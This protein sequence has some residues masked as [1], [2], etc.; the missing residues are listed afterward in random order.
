MVTG[1]VK[2]TTDFEKGMPNVFA[3]R[4]G[5]T[6]RDEIKDDQS[7]IINLRG[8]GLVIVSGC[9]HSGIINTV[10]YA[11]EITGIGDVYAITGGF[12]LSGPFFESVI[13]DTVNEIKRLSPQVLVPMHCTGWVATIRFFKEFSSSFVLNSVGSKITLGSIPV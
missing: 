13:E 8:K 7:L 12:H 3:Q 1:Y 2:R 5:K 9:S 10:R 6:E 11:Q 4:N